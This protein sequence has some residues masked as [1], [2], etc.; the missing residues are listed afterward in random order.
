[1]LRADRFGIAKGPEE[2]WQGRLGE[3]VK[4]GVVSRHTDRDI[5]EWGSTVSSE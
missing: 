4:L 3:P 1:M 5:A 2:W